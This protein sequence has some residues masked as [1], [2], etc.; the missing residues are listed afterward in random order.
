MINP[1]NYSTMQQ[2]ADPTAAFTNALKLGASMQ[3]LELKQAI[4]KRQLA[5]QDRI[6]EYQAKVREQG[7]TLQDYTNLAM[8]LPKDQASVIMDAWSR[9]STE[10]QQK[11]AGRTLELVTALRS[12]ATDVANSMMDKQIKEREAAGDTQ[13]ADFLKKYKEV[14]AINPQGV[15]DY[16]T[17]I[18]SLTPTG[19]N[20]LKTLSDYELNKK[21][22]LS[23][24]AQAGKYAAETKGKEIENQFAPK[25]LQSKL[26]TEAAQRNKM[27]ADVAN[28]RAR[29]GLESQRV[30]LEGQRVG[31]EGKRVDIEQQKVDLQKPDA[32]GNTPKEMFELKKT[33]PKAKG[34]LQSFNA[35]ADDTI[36]NINELLKDT[37]GLKKISG[38]TGDVVHITDA[39][40]RAKAKYETIKAQG[41]LNTLQGLKS[42]SP[43]GASGLGS[44]SNSEGDKLVAAAASLKQSQ[45]YD[46]LVRE[47][48]AYKTKIEESK[49]R[50]QSGFDETYLPVVR[51]K[52]EANRPKPSGNVPSEAELRARLS[53][54]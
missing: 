4:E 34:A 37:E 31:L 6:A 15:A 5:D 9:K 40:R 11:A 33:Y 23:E 26:D 51:Q 47:L 50:L 7:A 53:K 12:G 27:A 14:A 44:V 28:D 36:N 25:T 13:G 2:P 8:L 52:E 54:Y 45:S 46:D 20:A 21:K 49:K 17:S 43:T 41:F 29:I 48:K 22:A 32:Y 42:S 16:Y 39:S 38:L 3:D 18:L 10:D 24:E 1:I 30:G 35:S 19:Q